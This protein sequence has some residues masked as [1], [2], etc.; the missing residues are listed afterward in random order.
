LISSSIT[1]SFSSRQINPI[2]MRRSKVSTSF[3]L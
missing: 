1:P 2:T 3:I